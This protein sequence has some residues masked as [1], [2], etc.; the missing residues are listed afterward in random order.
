[1]NAMTT[2]QQPPSQGEEWRIHKRGKSC[3]SCQRAFR[4][5]EEHYSGIVEVQGRFERRDVCLGCWAGTPELFSFW[6]TRTPRREEKRLE[7]INA[8]QEFFKKL[9]EKP[10]E[11]PSRQKITYLTAL[12]LARKRR[13]KLAG[14]KDGKLR[15]EKGWDGETIESPDPPISDPELEGLKQQMEQLFEIEFSGD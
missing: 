13:L 5:E 15:I 12:L 6:K 11:E 14:S 7:D 8:M 9:L 3:S 10:S 2:P 4:S 1:M